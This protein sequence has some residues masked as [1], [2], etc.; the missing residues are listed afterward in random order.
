M[1]TKIM[2]LLI[3]IGIWSFI[4]GVFFMVDDYFFKEEW[5]LALLSAGVVCFVIVVSYYLYF[6]LLEAMI[7]G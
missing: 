4:F 3:I 7:V 5:A 1:V 2:A 6:A